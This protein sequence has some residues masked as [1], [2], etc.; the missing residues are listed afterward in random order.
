MFGLRTWTLSL[1]AS[2][3]WA[4]KDTSPFM[5]FSTSKYASIGPTLH[6]QLTNLI[7]FD[8]SPPS[9]ATNEAISSQIDSVI[10]KC[11]SDFYIVAHQPGVSSTDFRQPSTPH[12][13][14]Y[15]QKRKQHIKSSASV[16]EVVGDIDP[17][18]TV[19]ALQKACGAEPM[20]IDPLSE[21]CSL[22]VTV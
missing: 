21:R 7:R 14:E 5:L 9:I 15:V 1:S 13:R 22:T 18:M 11:S 16:S 8:W 10:S 19:K 12:L 20:A 2:A 4:F 3:A 6:H 17:E